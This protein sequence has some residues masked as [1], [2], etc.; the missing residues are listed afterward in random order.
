[1]NDFHSKENPASMP[2]DEQRPAGGAP[3]AAP[4]QYWSG[5]DTR[6]AE[7]QNQYS[8]H[9]AGDGGSY[10]Y[11]PNTGW[12]TPPHGP[13]W[14]FQSYDNMSGGKNSKKKRKRGV[15]IFA[16][17]ILCVLSLVLIAQSGVIIYRS[18]VGGNGDIELSGLE[19]AESSEPGDALPGDGDEGNVPASDDRDQATMRI[20]DKPKVDDEISPDGRLSIPQVARRLLPSVVSVE[21]FISSNFFEPYGLGSGIIMSEEGYIVTN[22]HVI[23]D[24]SALRVTLNTGESFEASIVG[25][26]ARTDLA[27]I[28]ITPEGVDLVA[29][30][31]GDSTQLEVG[32]TVI[33]VGNPASLE[34]A[35]S[36]TRGIVSALNRQMISNS[37]AMTYIQTDAA[38]NPG[39][40]GG[41]L[42]NEFGQVIGINTSKIV[43]TG[44][45]GIGFAIPISEAKP[46]IDDLVING[47]VTGRVKLGITAVAVDEIAS[48]NYGIPMGLM[49]QEIEAESDIAQK[50]VQSRD[51]ITHINGSRIYTFDELRKELDT[52]KVG[53]SVTL[54]IYRQSGISKGNTF[55]VTVRLMEDM[56]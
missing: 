18:I 56:G 6:R 30:E 45:E 42:A 47:R 7:G 39:N 25:T 5:Q 16:V 33:A 12:Q 55:D 36:V 50:G 19:S 43:S 20:N 17:S 13:E 14:N 48:R 2:P 26:D 8:A 22:Q 24:S 10:Q 44:F 3:D 27:V 11:N 54:T 29:A 1:M 34:L 46:I 41:A 53:D 32:E 52:H 23:A 35:G 49:I 15:M 38:I 28:K 21:S 4:E 51:I 31:F 40:S 37:D 9:R